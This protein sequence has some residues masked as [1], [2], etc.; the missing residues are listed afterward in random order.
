MAVLAHLCDEDA[1]APA[2]RLLELGGGGDGGGDL[3]ALVTVLI[4]VG[5]CARERGQIMDVVRA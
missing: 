4:E 3:V 2:V 5:A 1:R